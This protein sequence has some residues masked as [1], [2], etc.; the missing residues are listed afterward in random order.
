MKILIVDDEPQVAEILAKSLGRE[1]HQATIATSGEQ[2][3]SLVGTYDPDALFLDVSMPGMN[4]LDVLAEVRRLREGAWLDQAALE[5]AG[6]PMCCDISSSSPRAMIAVM[7]K[8]L[9][10][11]VDR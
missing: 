10:A 11:E 7:R 9:K 3:L 4:G 5:I 6:D 2:A 8:H 1:G